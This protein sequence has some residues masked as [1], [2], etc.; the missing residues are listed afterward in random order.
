MPTTGEVFIV[1]VGSSYLQVRRVSVT[2]VHILFM[3]KPCVEFCAIL[4]CRHLRCIR[5]GGSWGR[6]RAIGSE[7]GGVRPLGLIY[8]EEGFV[9]GCNLLGVLHI[10]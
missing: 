4:R 1:T 8:R 6:G 7:E 9:L 2:D 3:Q 10:L 5:D